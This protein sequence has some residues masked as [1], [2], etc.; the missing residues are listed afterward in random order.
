MDI[1]TII[2]TLL[3]IVVVLGVILYPLWQ[4]N[5]LKTVGQTDLAAQT[6]AEYQVRYQSALANIKDL[7]FDYEMGKLASA[8]YQNLLNKGK[9][10]AAQLRQQFD[11]LSNVSN[12]TI[13]LLITRMKESPVTV[14]EMLQREINTEIEQLK[15][16]SASSMKKKGSACPKCGKSYQANDAFCSGCG[17]TLVKVSKKSRK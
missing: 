14:D 2:V 4:H 11:D 12:D 9:L 6:R 15:K 1:A 16:M 10:E 8:D 7:M 3:L 17:Q 13:E 5:R